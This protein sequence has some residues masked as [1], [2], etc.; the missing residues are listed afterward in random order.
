MVQ[1]FVLHKLSHLPVIKLITRTSPPSLPL[2]PADRKNKMFCV[3]FQ[4]PHGSAK[5]KGKKEILNPPK[6]S[7]QLLQ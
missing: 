1:K 3:L 4:C 6:V 2:A 5:S 7:R